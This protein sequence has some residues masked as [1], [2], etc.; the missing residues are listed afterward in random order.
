MSKLDIL[1][2]F[3]KLEDRYVSIPEIRVALSPEAPEKDSTSYLYLSLHRL[4]N[5]GRLLT[6]GKAPHRLYRKAA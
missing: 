3:E 4:V 6:K 5:D 2:A 1:A